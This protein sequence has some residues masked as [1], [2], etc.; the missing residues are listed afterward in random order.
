M[1]T[2]GIAPSHRLRLLEESAERFPGIFYICEPSTKLLVWNP[3][4]ESATGLCNEQLKDLDSFKEFTASPSAERVDSGMQLI[5]QTGYGRGDVSIRHTSGHVT[6]FDVQSTAIVV[7]GMTLVA[8][9]GVDVTALRNSQR[10]LEAASRSLVKQNASLD[11]LRDVA[12]SL[13]NAVT[14]DSVVKATVEVIG[15][16]TDTDAIAIWTYDDQ[17]HELNILHSHQVPQHLSDASKKLTSDNVIAMTAMETG[18]ISVTD[19]SVASFS[20]R[21]LNASFL[22]AG[23]RFSVCAPLVA[24]ETR[25][26][27]LVW[28]MREAADLE[29]F[30]RSSLTTMTSQIAIA[31]LNARSRADLDYLAMHDV[32]TQLPNRNA[33]MSEITR[34]TD[35]GAQA[36]LFVIEL[37]TVSDVNEVFGH[38][39]GDQL[40]KVFSQR[41]L[42]HAVELKAKAFRFLGRKFCILVPITAEVEQ[43][44]NGVEPLIEAFERP[45]TMGN[46]DI[47][48]RVRI[49]MA[50]FPHDSSDPEELIRC[51]AV[52]LDR[53]SSHN[54]QFIVYKPEYSDEAVERLE[55]LEEIRSALDTPQIRL[56][57][58]PKIAVADLSVTGCEALVRWE[59]P[60]RGF[61]PPA[62]FIPL[63]ESTE[64]IHAFTRR[65]LELAIAQLEVWISQGLEMKVAVNLS[66]INLSDSG[67]LPT[68]QHLLAQHDV[69]PSLLQFEVTETGLMKDRK[70][71]QE[72]L[73]ELKALGTT[74]AIDDFGTGYSSLAYLKSLPLDVLKI[75]RT[76]V[77][78]LTDDAGDQVIVSSTINMA[79]NLGLGTVAEGVEALELLPILRS[80]GCTEAQG[81]GIAKP[82]IASDLSE[83]RAQW[84]QAHQ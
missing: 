50:R 74:L 3:A 34:L 47:Q 46:L 38:A 41:V 6:I 42:D 19:T 26:G 8:G 15:R 48:V 22:S 77:A 4:V 78:D 49:G 70:L 5:V 21:T 62:K 54:A 73:S 24:Q 23:F 27:L 10:E 25:V 67:L 28:S 37:L 20:E 72:Q 44:L 16:H 75:D 43:H 39:K 65:V 84:M 58:Q 60:A 53:A 71:A 63:V 32:G 51:T 14:L 68:V 45:I 61:V 33:L 55:L 80:M 59:H 79:S 76:F 57:F 9:Y 52:A 35:S 81:Y 66:A 36:A 11:L 7:D 2:P 13:L 29:N 31:M 30:E 18:A 1:E 83:W 40:L 69:N 82:M 64:L 12:A 56:H 17:T